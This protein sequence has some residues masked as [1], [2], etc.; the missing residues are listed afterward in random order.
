MKRLLLTALL[1]LSSKVHGDEFALGLVTAHLVDPGRVSERFE[2]CL[3]RSCEVIYN[4]IVAYRMLTKQGVDYYSHTL[5]YGTN[6][7]H[8]H[9]AGYFFSFGTQYSKNRFGAVMGTYIQDNEHFRQRGI[10]PFSIAEINATG[11]VPL[12]GVEHQYFLQKNLFTNIIITPV[13]ANFGLG[14]SW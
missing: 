11:F 10:E 9:M 2:G 4:P 6:S 1:L 3:H 8:D 13:V 14:I 12:V 7:I 5:L